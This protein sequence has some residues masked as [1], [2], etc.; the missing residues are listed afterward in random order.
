[1]PD[2]FISADDLSDYLGRDVTGDDGTV[3]A[4]DAA[5]DLVRTM[6]EQ[7]FNEATTTFTLD[8]TG[9][10]AILLP[11][12]PVSAVGTVTVDGEAVTDYTLNGNGILFRGSAGCDPRPTWPS[13][14]QNVVVTADHGYAS[15]DLPR[16]VRIVALQVAA[17]LIV[18]GVTVEEAQGAERV[19]YAGP[20]LDLTKG[21]QMILRKYRQTR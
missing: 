15:A 4:L 12:L 2:P 20:A 8:G 11:Y 14:R 13:G 10:D 3:I 19:R 5:C 18:Q 7:P 6:A 16:D 1:M 9:T 17:R 21:E